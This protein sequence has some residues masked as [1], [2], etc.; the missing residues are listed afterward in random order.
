MLFL[1]TK[2]RMVPIEYKKLNETEIREVEKKWYVVY[3]I[4]LI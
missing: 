2:H 4:G 3:V 1:P